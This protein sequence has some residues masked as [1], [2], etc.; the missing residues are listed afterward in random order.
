ME[1][2]LYIDADLVCS[3]I[4]KLG[5]ADHKG[6]RG[7]ALLIGGTK[8]K[9]GAICLA[10]AAAQRSGCGLATVFLPS[11]GYTVVQTA[12]P[13]VMVITDPHEDRIT[14]IDI[15][16]KIDAV[17]V[18]PGLG[19]NLMTYQALETFLQQITSPLVLDADALN[20]LSIY[21]QL[22]NFIRP[23]TIL[24][25]HIKEFER[26]NMGNDQQDL[27][28]QAKYLALHRKVIVVLKGAPTII[29]DGIYLFINTTGNPALAT[30]GSG[31][32]LT[33]IITGLLAQG[34]PP[35]D[36][37][38]AGVYLHGLC[39]DLAIEEMSMRS[40]VASDII[41]FL[42]KALLKINR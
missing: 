19:V 35:L 11:C 27:W 39:A 42:G 31:D 8:G 25:P 32:V 33:G 7:H 16:F 41:K 10:V 18:G 9:I 23:N 30:G 5:V 24:T 4:P 12:F 40:F 2:Q 37:A 26:L 34:I 20:C 15:P 1:S 21:A 29:T 17:G 14:K 3:M 22:W 38:V 36:A 6:T 13:E 28:Q